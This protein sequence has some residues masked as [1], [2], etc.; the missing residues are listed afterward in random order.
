MRFF[1]SLG[2]CCDSLLRG[3]C[4]E[5]KLC[6]YLHKKGRGLDIE[7]GEPWT[8]PGVRKLRHFIISLPGI[9]SVVLPQGG[10]VEGL[11]M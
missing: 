3:R 5:R 11:M 9:I 10:I 8:C 1:L 2:G 6:S 7:G 4:S